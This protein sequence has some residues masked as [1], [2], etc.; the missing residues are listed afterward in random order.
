MSTGQL[1]FKMMTFVDRPG[2]M[3]RVDAW[4]LARLGR[5][6]AYARGAMKKQ[7][8]P[9]LKGRGKL[10]RTVH[11]KPLPYDMPDSWKGPPPAHMSVIVPIKGPALDAKT[12][13]PVGRKMADRA[14][15]LLRAN[16]KGQGEGRPPRRGPTDKLRR[17]IFFQ[18][19][20][21]NESVVIGPEKFSTQPV[22][23]NRV[24]VPELLNKGGVEVVFGT[25]VH[26]GPRPYVETILPLAVNKI[27]SDIK[28]HP[29][30]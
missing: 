10:N 20:V 3:R 2:V 24:S 26:Y 13:R 25:R 28:A 11:F 18:I 6:G 14:R 9:A 30:R 27:L 16:K 5:V 7:I 22:M 23:L 19:D 12:G 29:V 15:F 8:R 21:P 4:K 1:N 17:F